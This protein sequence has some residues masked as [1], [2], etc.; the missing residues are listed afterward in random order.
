M[1]RQVLNKCPVCGSRRVAELIYGFVIPDDALQAKI[2]A[3]L[4]A[5]GGCV[6][7]DDSPIRECQ[8]CEHRWGKRRVRR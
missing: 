8:D 3:G 7:N 5:M 2:D 6:V 4:I 1:E